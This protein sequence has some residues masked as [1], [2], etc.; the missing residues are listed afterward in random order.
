MDITG[1]STSTARR[2]SPGH[3]IVVALV[4]ATV[5]IV[6]RPFSLL[7]PSVQRVEWS[8]PFI[9]QVRG[10]SFIENQRSLWPTLQGPYFPELR[11]ILSL[12]L[13]QAI[14]ELDALVTSCPACALPGGSFVLVTSSAWTGSCMVA[15]ARM[16]RPA[17][18][19]NGF[20][21]APGVC[22]HEHE[23][24]IGTQSGCRMTRAAAAH[25]GAPEDASEDAVSCQ[26]LLASVEVSPRL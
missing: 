17:D 14:C 5:Q 9:F 8:C 12:K 20:L 3:D 25:G 26:H 15:V 11:T 2:I 24:G 13:V 6:S 23:V 18:G 1:T 22:G 19:Y 10:S 4:D 21:L 7:I 16:V